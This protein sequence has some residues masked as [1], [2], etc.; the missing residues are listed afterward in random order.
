M[1]ENLPRDELSTRDRVDN[2]N[3]GVIAGGLILFAIILCCVP[4]FWFFLPFVLIGLVVLFLM[5]KTNLGKARDLARKHMR[6]VHS[7]LDVDFSPGLASSLVLNDWGLYF[8][9]SGKKPVAISWDNVTSI[10]ELEIAILKIHSG[11]QSPIEVDL[12]QDRYYLA[13][14]SLY[15]KIPDKVNLFVDPKSGSGKLVQRLEEAPFEFRGK[16]GHFIMDSLGVE[17]SQSGRISWDAITRVQENENDI[18]DLGAIR[19]LV[20]T[21]GGQS[22]KLEEKELTDNR[23]IGNTRYDLI[24]AIL[25]D[26]IPTKVSFTLAAAS[27]RERA[28]QEFDRENEITS[29]SMSMAIK[30]GKYAHLEPRFKHME[31]LVDTFH[32]EPICD[33]RTFFQDYA[34]MLARTNRSDEGKKLL[35]RVGG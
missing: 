31:W 20:F 12:S 21:A 13:T 8:A 29:K 14:R 33:T 15:S 16:F 35:Q 24:K 27:A 1:S 32:L 26:R 5:G 7:E 3:P 25:D 17:H 2:T 22:F 6:G 10:E 19:E 23:T 28:K 30:S 18:E 4:I 9:T 11:S 34:E